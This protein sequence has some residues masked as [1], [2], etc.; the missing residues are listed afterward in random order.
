MTPLLPAP[1]AVIELVKCGCTKSRCSSNRCNC[2]KAQ[3]SCTDLCCCCEND[4]PRENRPEDET[5][6]DI[7]YE[8]DDEKN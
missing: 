5:V 7:D 8:N 6:H 1:K 3:L 4:D 2:R